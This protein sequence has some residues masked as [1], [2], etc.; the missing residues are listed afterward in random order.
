M[1]SSSTLS[2]TTQCA[3]ETSC[4]FEPTVEPAVTLGF[5][6][7]LTDLRQSSAAKSAVSQQSSEIEIP[8]NLPLTIAAAIFAAAFLIFMGRGIH[9]Q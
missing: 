7:A 9:L 8:L 3:I 1:R 6:L 5:F 2:S 4:D